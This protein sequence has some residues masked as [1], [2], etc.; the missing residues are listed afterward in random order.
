[1]PSAKGKKDP[2]GLIWESPGYHLSTKS[3]YETWDIALMSITSFNNGLE[4][5]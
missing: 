3:N 4:R 1:M 2:Q 5:C